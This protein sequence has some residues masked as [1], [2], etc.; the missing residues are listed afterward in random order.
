[1]EGLTGRMR[2]VGFLNRPGEGV[3]IAGT[4]GVGEGR[5]LT[6]GLL[7]GKIYHPV[8]VGPEE[9]IHVIEKAVAAVDEGSVVTLRAEDGAERREIFAALAAQD[10]LSRNRRN[11]Q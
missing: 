8:A 11:R 4:P 7:S 10:G 2:L 1:M 6:G 5:L 3:L 9:V